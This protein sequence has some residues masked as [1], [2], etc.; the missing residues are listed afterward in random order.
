MSILLFSVAILTGLTIFYLLFR[1]KKPL[2]QPDE[3]T[4]HS[5]LTKYVDFY[6]KRNDIQRKEFLY[7]MRFFLKKVKITGIKTKVEDLDRVLIAA[8]ATIPVFNFKNWEY[9]N[10]QEILLYPHSFSSD[11]RLQGDNRTIIGE[12]GYGALQNIMILS[13]PD[14]RGGFLLPNNRSNTAIHE[15]VHLIDKMDGATDGV[16]EVVPSPPHKKSWLQCIEIE[17][18]RIK[19][20]KSDINPYALTN[21]AEFFAVVSEYFFMQ[22]SDMKIKHPD[23]FSMLELIFG[24]NEMAH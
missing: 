9:S 1:K 17:M 12:V 6:R 5:L 23:L 20:G 16:P 15:F 21:K 8:A 2:P 24:E 18:L 14:L 7:R 13:Q 19:E 11:F 4:E 10:V 22:P 3:K